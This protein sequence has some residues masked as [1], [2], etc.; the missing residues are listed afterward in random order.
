MPENVT[1]LLDAFSTAPPERLDAQF[2]KL[3]GALADKGAANVAAALLG[4]LDGL[5]E[6]SQGYAVLLLG[7][8]AGSGDDTARETA[9]RGLDRYLGLLGRT[10][11]G[12]PLRLALLYLAGQFEADRERVLTVAARLDLGVDDLSRLERN[13]QRFD[14]DDV[15][16]GRVWPSPAAWALTEAEREFDQRWIRALTHEQAVT[17]WRSD[18]QMTRGYSGAKALWALRNGAPV[19]GPDPAGSEAALIASAAADDSGGP[20]LFARHAAAF[21]CP[22]CGDRLSFEDGQARCVSCASAYSTA[23]G[24]LNLTAAL[25]PERPRDPKDVLQNA[26]VL[27]NIGHYYETVLRPAFL[28]LMGSNW[29]AAVSPA[30]EDAYLARNTRPVGDGPV[31]DLAAGAGRWTSVLAQTLGAS[32]VI[33]LDL[34]RFML[35]WLRGRLP[36]VPAV[37]AS[38]LTLPFEDGTLS[39]VNCWNA[40]QTLPD[41]AAVIAE[42]G[43]CLRPGGSFTLMT[44]RWADDPVYRSFQASFRGP[45]FPDGMPL[46]EVEQLRSWLEKAGLT[47]REET[48][49]GTFVLF[50]CERAR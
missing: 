24:I 22:A 43:R 23:D 32:R 45:G 29:G 47:V 34:N 48:T 35:T 15:V 26:A 12:E 5:G 39:A 36:D 44:F 8:L 4:R 6:E 50:A 30:D 18:T 20:G 49:P 2:L 3:A 17:A 37:Q 10:G 13:L 46:F 14:P 7:L 42:V 41:P 11:I 31:L 19:D 28:R 1:A 25:D 27:E 9:R 38:A 33:A 21:R 16:L 40:L